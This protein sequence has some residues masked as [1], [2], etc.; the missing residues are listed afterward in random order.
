M[1]NWPL[2]WQL[3][4]WFVG[5][6]AGVALL[7][8]LVAPL[9]LKNFFGS[10]L[11]EQLFTAQDQYIAR[12][13]QQNANDRVPYDPA[14]PGN[15]RA[16]RHMI[17]SNDGKPIM[18]PGS[19]RDFN[20]RTDN[21]GR[22]DFGGRMGRMQESLLLDEVK[23]VKPD[24]P[25]R[26]VRINDQ[27]DLV[28]A[29]IAPIK[30]NEQQAVIVS[31]LQGT[32]FNQLVNTLYQQLLT[33]VLLSLVLSWI[34]AF[35]LARF[36]SR[37][38]VQIQKHVQRIA[39]HEWHEPL[40]TN[41]KD[42]IGKLSFAVDEM[43]VQLIQSEQDQQT[44]LQ[45]LSHEMKTPVMIIRSYI[46]SIKDGV[47]PRGDLSLSLETMDAQ[48]IRLQKRISDLIF[49]TKLKHWSEQPL[50]MKPLEFDRLVDDVIDQYRHHRT[51]MEWELDLE[52]VA[53][54]GDVSRWQIALENLFENQLRYAKKRIFVQLS[55]VVEQYVDAESLKPATTVVLV[56]E[57]DGD[58]MPEALLGNRFEPFQKGLGGQHG[59]GLAIAQ[60]IF[61][62]HQA[63]LT[64]E[65]IHEG[66][67][68]R[69]EWPQMEEIISLGSVQEG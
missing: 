53:V 32:Y 62:I 48:T 3:W 27:N 26:M 23:K 37:P 36:L 69:I 56:I 4:V 9:S 45:H 43:R 49:F 33:I 6:V 40:I 20:N 29:A 17:F 35:F 57:N 21:N 24:D 5:M 31:T 67:R 60:R 12:M 42:E 8:L 19:R 47:F 51:E 61:D 39:K 1:K 7:I 22:G 66:V 11:T 64:V 58:P 10:E 63:K 55:R 52:P 14:M 28:F 34:P 41:R 25:V 15:L 18:Q 65:N 30:I 68:F 2:F 38:L 54:I 13:N 59:L 46:Q 44:L 50:Q 16:V